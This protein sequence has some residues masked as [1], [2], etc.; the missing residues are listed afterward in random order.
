M[1]DDV[2]AF[3]AAMKSKQVH[4]SPVDEAT[5]GLNHAALASRRR[6]PWRL[7][8]EPPLSAPRQDDLA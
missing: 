1:C 5:L 6:K 7:L 2:Q 4:C 8:A 3:I